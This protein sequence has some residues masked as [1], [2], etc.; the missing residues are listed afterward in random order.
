MISPFWF[1]DNTF[2]LHIANS[3]LLPAIVADTKLKM[4]QVSNTHSQTACTCTQPRTRE[5]MHMKYNTRAL[6]I[7][8]PIDESP[9][10]TN[11]ILA[12]FFFSSLPQEKWSFN[13][14][15]SLAAF[16]RKDEQKYIHSYLIFLK[17]LS[18]TH[19]QTCKMFL[20]MSLQ[21]F[22][23]SWFRITPPI[24]HLWLPT[25]LFSR[26]FPIIK[27][28]Q[29]ELFLKLKLWFNQLTVSDCNIFPSILY[30]L[31]L[32]SYANHGKALL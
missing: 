18:P 12:S 17:Q 8:S 15:L 19:K 29:A 21:H 26:N 16:L 13:L 6:Q 27:S 24:I 3:Q 30:Q 1:F 11:S 32:K 25:W 28:R 7:D 4:N 5:L 23:I 14:Q 9:A 2:T 20:E 22:W 31:F 10:W